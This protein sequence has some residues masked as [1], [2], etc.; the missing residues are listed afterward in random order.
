[1]NRLDET[2]KYPQYPGSALFYTS[3]ERKFVIGLYNYKLISNQSQPIVFTNIAMYRHWIK[4][5]VQHANLCHK[6]F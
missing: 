3:G 4:E 1:M 6:F 5:N 2:S